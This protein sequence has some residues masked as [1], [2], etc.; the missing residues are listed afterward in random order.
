MTS[1]QSQPA[2]S[3]DSIKKLIAK[4]GELEDVG[5]IGDKLHLTGEQIADVLW[6]T[7]ELQKFATPP[8]EEEQELPEPDETTSTESSDLEAKQ[9]K[10][11]DKPITP[12]VSR[13]TET[14]KTAPEK[15]A[16]VYTSSSFKESQGLPI[17][18]PDA[19]SLR[20][21]LNF[22]HGFRPLMRQ[23]ATGRKVILDEAATVK[24]IAEEL[25]LTVVMKAEGEQWLDLALVI[26]ESHSMLIWGHTIKELKKMLKKYGIFRDM[27]IFGLQPDEAGENLQVFSRTGNNNRLIEPKEIIDP[28]GR[29]V[30]LIVSDCVSNIWRKGMMFPVLK[31]WTQKQPLAILQ[32]LPEWMWRRTALDLGT[33]VGFK[34]SVM[35]LANQELSLHKPLR[36]SQRMG[37]NPEERSKVPVITLNWEQITQWSQMLVGKGDA[38]VPGYLLPPELEVEELEI[39]HPLLKRQQQARENP[40]ATYIVDNFQRFTSP[41][42][43]KLASLLAASP[44][45]CLPV[46]RLIQESLLPK[47]NQVQLA[48]VFLGGLLKPNSAYVQR[49][50]NEANLNPDLV[51]YEF[52]EPKIRDIFLDDAPVS[53]SVDVVNAVSRY[54]AEK[55]G[56]SLSEFRAI[57]KAPENLEEKKKREDVV[58]PFAE[59]TAKILK[60]LEGSYAR[61]AEEI[62]EAWEDKLWESKKTTSQFKIP[63]AVV[64]M[65]QEEA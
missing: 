61:F 53:D 40:D 43:R 48:E 19:P 11:D 13:Q 46:V 62:E 3:P 30:V 56:V 10:T 6:L 39:D 8:S 9:L 34:S 24:R 12:P 27:R 59:I 7:L 51:E 32:M 47:S 45:I 18:V 42:G 4:L 57:L 15:K 64:V 49:L 58:K 28:T 17:G 65:T 20:D 55:L 16:S 23:V 33:A 44:V 50:S 5:D 21:P 60:R 38:R 2:P 26:D 22:A 37:F 63:I 54:V 52:I 25:I 29:R 31:T 14:T 41:L 1:S 35:G 36:R